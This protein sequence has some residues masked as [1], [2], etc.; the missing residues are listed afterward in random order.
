MAAPARE[1]S[2]DAL[3][4][5]DQPWTAELA[6]AI[7]P[8]TNGPKIEVIEGSL[9]LTPHADVDHQDVEFHLCV[10]MT[11]GARA[12]G[13]WVYHEINVT[14]GDDLFIP[15]ISVFRS[16]GGGRKAMPI[17]EAVLLCEIVSRGSRRKDL[18]DKPRAY[19]TAGVP[20]YLRVEFR[21]R[22]PTL[23]LH[24]LAN[25]AYEPVATGSGHFT[26]NEPFALSVDPAALVGPEA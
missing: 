15:D 2:F 21:D 19:A 20:W 18:L 13:L 14:S 17:S 16:P 7:L 8:E 25:G 12:A 22:V 10:Q 23:V 4:M 11:D 24:R 1:P 6:L 26:M 5:L 9:V 3:S